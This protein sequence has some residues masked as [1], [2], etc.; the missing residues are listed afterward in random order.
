MF[1]RESISNIS[2]LQHLIYAVRSIG[3]AGTVRITL[4]RLNK[5]RIKADDTNNI[6]QEEQPKRRWNQFIKG[7]EHA[8]NSLS[9]GVVVQE[10]TEFSHV[11]I[12]LKRL[13]DFILPMGEDTKVVMEATGCYHGLVAHALH[14]KG[15]I[16]CVNL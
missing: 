7:K 3:C 12:E 11:E 6:Y 4:R 8:V 16:V 10:P 14:E 1:T 5:R 15:I 13:A 2:R 9:S